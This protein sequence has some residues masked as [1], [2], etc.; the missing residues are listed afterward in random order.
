M[1]VNVQGMIN[2]FKNWQGKITYDMG[3]HKIMPNNYVGTNDCSGG[4]CSAVSNN[5]GKINLVSTVLLGNELQKNGFTRIAVNQDWGSKAGDIIL[6]SWGSSMTSSGGAGGHVGILIDANNFISVDYWTGGA[7]GTAVSVHNWND[8]YNTEARTGLQYVEV[9]RYAGNT[10]VTPAPAVKAATVIS[11]TSTPAIEAFKKA[12]NEF[13]FVK[14]I[15]VDAIKTYNGIPQF[16]NYTLTPKD[17]FDWGDNGI[18]LAIVKRVDGKKD[19][20]GVG[21]V[22]QFIPDYRSGAID[23]YDVPTNAV[24][25]DYEGYGRIWYKADALLNKF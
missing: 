17:G 14:N 6:M 4:I 19:P 18:P 2:S 1:T 7:R 24:G 3:G 12:N 10:T 9:W 22:V 23:A 20:I 15:T 8:Y 13:Q 21:A 5:G 25:I 11:A 16:A